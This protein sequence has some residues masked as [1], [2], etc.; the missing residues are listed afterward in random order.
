MAI[1]NQLTS[2]LAFI[3]FGVKLFMII[4]TTL[5]MNPAGNNPDTIM[6]KRLPILKQLVGLSAITLSMS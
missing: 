1:L 2:L 6:V 3:K 4:T 5:S